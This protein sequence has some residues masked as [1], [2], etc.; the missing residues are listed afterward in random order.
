M[1]PEPEI[2]A[3]KSRISAAEREVA[4]LKQ[5]VM[6]LEARLPAAPPSAGGPM[7]GPSVE[8]AVPPVLPPVLP[9]LANPPPL[10]AA[11]PPRE[12]PLR[13][14]LEPLQLWPPSGDENRE[15]RLAAWWTTRLGAALAV[16]GIA[17]FAA[18]VSRNTSAWVRMLELLGLTTVFLAAGFWTERRLPK[19]GAVVVGAGLALV[20][21]CAFAAFALPAVK[22]IESPSVAFGW[23]LAAVALVFAASWWRNS[24]VTAAMAVV[25]GYVAA[26]F[27]LRHGAELPALAASLLLNAAAVAL[28]WT[29]RWE[30]P[31]ALAVPLAWLLFLSVAFAGGTAAEV[32]L[33][34]LW[35]WAALSFG[36][37]FARDW[38]PAWRGTQLPAAR[39]RVVATV[40]SS[41]AL[42]CGVSVTLSLQHGSLGAFY[43]VAAGFMLGAAMAWWRVNREEALAA[44]F[45]CKAASLL[46]LGIMTECDARTRALVLLGQCAVLIVSAQ[47]SQLRGSRAMA[48]IVWVAANAMFIWDLP[49]SGVAVLGAESLAVAG[50]ILAA[51]AL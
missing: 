28:R 15:T 10:V 27:S 13:E 9:A 48:A 25:L 41:L 29:R 11:L 22:V 40:A 49:D 20:Y 3:L 35:A 7:V 16:I 19:F 33:Q 36:L 8:A 31:S 5:E 30:A 23:Q 1:N 21:F 46:A 32:S 24:A 43:F 18:Y 44:V 37:Q 17:F 2:A 38:V 34:T 47:R 12:N 4:L 50:F 6:L 42:A 51:S 26:V 45:F 39:D 14:W